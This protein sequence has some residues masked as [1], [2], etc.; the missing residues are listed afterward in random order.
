VKLERSGK[1]GESY[2]GVVGVRNP[3]TIGNI[4]HV[5]GCQLIAVL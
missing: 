2:V 4:D 3:Y 1:I 5:T